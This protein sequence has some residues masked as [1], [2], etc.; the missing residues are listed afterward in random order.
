MLP[1]HPILKSHHKLH[2]KKE[3]PVYVNLVPRPLSKCEEESLAFLINGFLTDQAMLLEK[4]ENERTKAS[5]IKS[6]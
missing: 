6:L 1:L 2:P 5:G 3:V 4:A